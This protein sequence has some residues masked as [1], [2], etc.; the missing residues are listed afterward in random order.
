MHEFFTKLLG[1]MSKENMEQ[2][3]SELVSEW[4]QEVPHSKGHTA[5][6]FN[7]IVK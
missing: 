3:G 6:Q 1:A 4:D 7:E 2:W 5:L